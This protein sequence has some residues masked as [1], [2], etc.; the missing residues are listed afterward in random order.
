M[1]RIYYKLQIMETKDLSVQELEEL[2]AKKKEEERQAALD[3]RAAYEGIRA[4][5]V[6]SIRNKV[7]AVTLDVE[8][9]HRFVTGETEAFKDVMAEYGQLRNQG[10]MSFRIQDENFRIEVKSNKVKKFDERADVAAVRLIEFLQNWIKSAEDGAENPMYQLAMVLLDRNK[11]GDLDYK[12]ISKLYDLESKF[13]DKEYSEIMTLFKES[14]LVEGTATNFYFFRRD[15][16]GVWRKIEPSF[17][18]M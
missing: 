7:E 18:R 9:L 4:E 16:L 6:V 3:R 5:T 17:N 13:A 2:L 12:N 1:M 11:Q 14:H 8:E 15:D 10:Q